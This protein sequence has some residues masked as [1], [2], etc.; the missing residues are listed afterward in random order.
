MKQFTNLSKFK[1]RCM[2]CGLPLTGPVAANEHAKE[3]GHDTFG[4]V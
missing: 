3:T 4:E 1:L 2:S